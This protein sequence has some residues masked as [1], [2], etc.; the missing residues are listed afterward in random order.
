MPPT[1]RFTFFAGPLQRYGAF[2]VLTSA[3][4][5]TFPYLQSGRWSQYANETRRLAA[6][7]EW[8]ALTFI[9]LAL[10]VAVSLWHRAR[11]PSANRPAY[12]RWGQ[13][14]IGAI[15]ILLIANLFFGGQ[16]GGAVAIAYNLVLCRVDLAHLCRDAHGRP[17]SGQYRFCFLRPHAAGP[18]LRYLLDA[19]QSIVLLHDRWPA[20]IAGGYL[21]ER[22]RRQ[23]S[24]DIRSREHGGGAFCEPR[25]AHCH[26]R[27][28]AGLRHCSPW[29]G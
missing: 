16:H 14:L 17:F 7:S 8:L 1:I 10:V 12:L 20:V 11:T 29:W 24:A 9:A 3:W 28:R 25:P 13:G 4:A 6:S 26:H 27:H 19:A 22:K 2:A 21:M 23:I 15:V 18:V 5:L